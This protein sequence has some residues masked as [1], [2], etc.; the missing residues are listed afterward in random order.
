M[1]T[2]SNGAKYVQSELVTSSLRKQCSTL[3]IIRDWSHSKI[4]SS[5]AST[6]TLP[7]KKTRYHVTSIV[8]VKPLMSF[9]YCYQCN[10]IVEVHVGP[11]SCQF[12]PIN[13]SWT[14][15][16]PQNFANVRTFSIFRI[17]QYYCELKVAYCFTALCTDLLCFRASSREKWKIVLHV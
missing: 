4:L 10:K 6:T 7:I 8:P 16:A 14:I 1:T 12:K 13:Y 9:K 11:D 17:I 5:T 15:I 2:A 3:R